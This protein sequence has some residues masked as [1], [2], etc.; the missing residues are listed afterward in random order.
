MQGALG[1]YAPMLPT[2]VLTAHPAEQRRVR[3]PHHGHAPNLD[4]VLV[5]HGGALSES[6]PST[7]GKRG[8]TL[9]SSRCGAEN[10]LALKSRPNQ[11]RRQL[12]H[13]MSRAHSVARVAPSQ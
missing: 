10:G 13:S 8:N 1:D 4:R 11:V 7:R 2:A 9:P 12:T 3:L 5:T 6:A